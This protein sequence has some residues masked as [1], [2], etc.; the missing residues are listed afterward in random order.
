MLHKCECDN[1]V[2][3]LKNMFNA[4]LSLKNGESVDDDGISAEHFLCTSYNVFVK[5]MHLFNAMLRHS[6][7]P[8]QFTFGSI[9]GEKIEDYHGGETRFPIFACK[10]LPKLGHFVNRMWLMLTL[11]I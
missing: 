5:L 4:V 7:V 3:S 2:I 11:T 1:R 8:K 10:S 9:I 6:Y